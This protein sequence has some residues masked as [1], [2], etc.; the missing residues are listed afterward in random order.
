MVVD[1]LQFLLQLWL[2]FNIYS[3]KV[4]LQRSLSTT[5]TLHTTIARLRVYFLVLEFISSS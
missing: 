5:K 1:M 4:T 2:L 3:L